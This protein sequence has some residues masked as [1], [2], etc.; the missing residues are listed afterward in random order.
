MYLSDQPNG[1]LNHSVYCNFGKA[2]LFHSKGYKVTWWFVNGKF[3]DIGFNFYRKERWIV[4]LFSAR[5]WTASTQPSQKESAVL[6]V[7]VTPVWLTTSPTTSGKP[8]QMATE[9]QGLVALYGRWWD[10]LAQ[11]ANARYDGPAG[12]VMERTWINSGS[13]SAL[14][15]SH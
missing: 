9:S 3:N 14:G 8:V 15:G 13:L 7:S 10:L 12:M 5:L 2:V 4:G 11:P 1:D 6:T